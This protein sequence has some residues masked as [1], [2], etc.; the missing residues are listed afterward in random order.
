MAERLLLAD[1]SNLSYRGR[2]FRRT[3][4]AGWKATG[5]RERIRG[6][7]TE[8]DASDRPSTSATSPH[9]ACVRL[10]ADVTISIAFADMVRELKATEEGL[11]QSLVLGR[12]THVAG[13]TSSPRRHPAV[14]R[15]EPDPIGESS[16][17]RDRSN[18]RPTSAAPSALFKSRPSRIRQTAMT[19]GGSRDSLIHRGSTSVC[20]APT[21]DCNLTTRREGV[22]RNRDAANG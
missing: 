18:D 17:P 5:C 16:A 14:C 10:E 15:Q 21:H 19:S 2:R 22:N 1:S 7:R 6:A 3:S 9:L 8:V 12:E 11:D 4:S 13:L 20:P